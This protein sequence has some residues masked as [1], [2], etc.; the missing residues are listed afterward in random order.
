[1]PFT[2]LG[3][4]RVKNI[5]S[6]SLRQK[7]EFQTLSGKKSEVESRMRFGKFQQIEGASSQE[8]EWVER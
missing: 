2:E 3:K 6:G 5:K 8:D 7:F 4:H 1:M